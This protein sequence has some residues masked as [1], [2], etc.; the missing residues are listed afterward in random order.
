[1]KFSRRSHYFLLFLFAI[2][3]QVQTVHKYTFIQKDVRKRLVQWIRS[4]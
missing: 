4:V 3:M 2:K 1:M